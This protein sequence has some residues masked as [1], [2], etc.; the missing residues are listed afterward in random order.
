MKDD[1][2]SFD[3]GLREVAQH[4][5]LHHPHPGARPDTNVSTAT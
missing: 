3:E 1:G 5:G 2:K 4:S